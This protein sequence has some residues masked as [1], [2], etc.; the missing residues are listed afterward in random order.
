MSATAFDVGAPQAPA[1]GQ[2]G[3]GVRVSG[4]MRHSE[5]PVD[6]SH[7]IPT[8]GDGIRDAIAAAFRDMDLAAQIGEMVDAKLKTLGL[9]R[10]DRRYL[11]HPETIT[12]TGQ[13]GERTALADQIWARTGVVAS[14]LH[15]AMDEW[16]RFV[17]FGRMP[18]IAEVTRALSEGTDA[19]GGYVVPP[20]FI[21]EI[22][23]DAP[24]ISALYQ[25]ARRIPVRT[26]AGEI[27]RVAT[28][29]S[30]SWGS[31]NT[32]MGE[33]DPAF[34]QSTWTINRMNALV[35]QSRELAND[36]NPNIVEFVTGLFREKIVE[37]R[38]RVV[39]VGTGSGQ[40]LGLYSATGI[41]DMDSITS[42]DYSALVDIHET[43]D[44]RYFSMPNCRWQF[45]QNVKADIMKIYDD[46]GRP[47][48]Q[49][50]PTEA[51]RPRLLG[52]PISIENSLPNNYVGFGDLRFYL[53]F[54]RETLGVERST[55]AG[56]A[57]ATH[58]L[59]IKFWER[60]DGKPV[61]PPTVPLVRARN[62]VLSN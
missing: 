8:N 24:K 25:W 38:D 20:G 59:W 26:M 16:F 10:V 13:Q 57:F 55:E 4:G 51:F 40:P 48:I 60:W 17:L 32:A 50:D 30:V 14:P 42:L 39:A 31:E 41:T 27:P 19:E 29:A 3:S 23:A 33:G 53:V 11:A 54:D 7:G 61:L 21:A 52:H 37:E 5:R 9:D 44:Q 34:G 6:S 36:S 12:D 1:V 2:P 45:N 49:L 47:L 28:N 35:K 43:V 15:R 62:V 22:V 56:T 46:Q 58:Q 18:T